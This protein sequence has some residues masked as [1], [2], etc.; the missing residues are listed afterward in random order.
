MIVLEN[1]MQ[2]DSFCAKIKI[3]FLCGIINSM[4]RELKLVRLV[5]GN[6][7]FT[8]QFHTNQED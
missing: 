7:L 1:G 2:K 8:N 4:R 6:I 5:I 3:K